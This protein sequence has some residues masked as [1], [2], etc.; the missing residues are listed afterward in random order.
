M[1]KFAVTVFVVAIAGALC[2]FAGIATNMPEVAQV[3]FSGFLA[4]F[5]VSLAAT[6]VGERS[7]VRATVREPARLRARLGKSRFD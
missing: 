5:V 6:L 1:A 4:L 7:A 2:G 3:V